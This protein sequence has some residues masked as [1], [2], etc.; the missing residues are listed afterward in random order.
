MDI[1]TAYQLVGTYRGAAEICGTT[2]K[3]VKRV[4]ERL[5]GPRPASRVRPGAAP[6]QLRG[7]PD[8]GHGRGQRSEGPGQRQAAA[9][10]SAR[11]RVRRVGPQLP[12]PGRAGETALPARQR[13]CPTPGGWSP[14]EHLVIDWG[15]IAGV[16]VFCAVLAWSR[17]RFV[18]FAADEKP[19]TTLALLAECFEVLGGVPGVS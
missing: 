7:R 12:P 18:R 3:T 19:D 9:A 2:H 5:P 4:I 6:E 15:V 17:L 14:G 11:G 1:I 16:H 13:A 8:R 10:E